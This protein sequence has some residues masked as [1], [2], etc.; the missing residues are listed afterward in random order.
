MSKTFSQIK[1][2]RNP[3]IVSIIALLIGA[4]YLA[5]SVSGTQ[6][7]LLIVGGLLGVSLYFASFGFTYAWRV[8]VADR[9]SGGLRAQMIMLAIGVILFFPFLSQ[10]TI[11]GKTVVGNVEAISLS[12]V[13]GAFLFGIGMQL[14]GGCGSGT[15]FTVGGGNTR[16][17]ITLIFFIVGSVIGAYTFSAWSAWPAFAPYSEIQNWGL[18]PAL[19]INLIVFALIYFITSA[20]EKRKHGKVQPIGRTENNQQSLIHGPWPLVWGA[21]A[22][23]LLNF[24][25]LA[26]AGK[27]WGVTSAFA[28]WGAK[29]LY[30]SGIDTTQWAYFAKHP[31]VITDSVFKNV[32]SVMDFGIIIGAVIAASA[33]GKFA[34]VWRLSGHAILTAIIGGLLL[35]FGARLAFGCNIGAYFSGIISGSLHAWLWLVCAFIG[36]SVGVYLRPLFELPVEKKS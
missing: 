2:N 16:M 8:F 34:P 33:A 5:G 22:L 25:T 17:I 24:A 3:L 23:V 36:S 13:V 28:I 7:S 10:G 21:V 30:L 19:I 31:N 1:I 14:G 27:P 29:I 12:V 32:T 26:L 18:W 9:R 35:G 6:A 20:L 11:F 15:L 4:Y